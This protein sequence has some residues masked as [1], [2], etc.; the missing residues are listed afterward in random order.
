MTTALLDRPTLAPDDPAKATAAVE[1]LAAQPAW[2]TL[3]AVQAGK[4]HT[5]PATGFGVTEAMAVRDDLSSPLAGTR[6]R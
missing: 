1:A 2:R 3:R 5:V 4:A 6:P